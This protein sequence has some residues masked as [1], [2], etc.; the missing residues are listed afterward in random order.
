[1]GRSQRRISGVDEYEIARLKYRSENRKEK[2][3]KK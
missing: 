2:K 1:M 3:K